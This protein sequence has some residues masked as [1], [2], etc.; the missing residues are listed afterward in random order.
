MRIGQPR[1]QRMVRGPP[2]LARIGPAQRSLL[3]AV[4]LEYR[5]VQIQT[6]SRRTFRKPCQLA[7]PQPGKKLLAL[8]LAKALEQG[9]QSVVAGKTRQAQGLVQRGVTT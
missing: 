9:A 4:A 2:M 5:G 7:A 8:S 6:V 1:Q 3:L